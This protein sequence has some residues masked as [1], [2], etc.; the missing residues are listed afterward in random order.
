MKVMLFNDKDNFDGCIRALN[1]GKDEAHKRFFKLDKCHELI[2]KKI[3][4]LHGWGSGE[5]KLVRTYIYTGRYTSRILESH[6]KYCNF[7]IKQFSELISKEDILL[8][9]ITK[10][11]LPT[12]LKNKIDDHVTNVK[13]HFQKQKEN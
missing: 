1:R 8:N 10:H 13:A 2:F 7:Q 12:T 3:S 6:K 4:S 11:S 5:I 9:E